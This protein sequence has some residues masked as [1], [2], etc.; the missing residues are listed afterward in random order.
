MFS[1]PKRSALGCIIPQRYC[2]A[3][4][5]FYGL[6]ILM[7]LLFC[8]ALQAQTSL[9]LDHPMYGSTNSPLRTHVIMKS[10][11]VFADSLTRNFNSQR[12]PTLIYLM[13][14][15]DFTTR[16]DSVWRYL[17]V[18]LDV[19]LIDSVTLR[20]D[21][22]SGLYFIPSTY[23]SLYIKNLA[24]ASVTNTIYKDTVLQNIF[25]TTEGLPKPIAYSFFEA[26]KHF[27]YC[28]DTLKI[29]LS[30]T[31]SSLNTTQGNVLQLEE[32]NGW[33]IDTSTQTSSTSYTTV[34]SNRW[35]STDNKTMFI[36]PQSGFV[37]GKTYR[38]HVN[39]GYITGDS[40]DNAFHMIQ[41]NATVPVKIV[42]SGLTPNDVFDSTFAAT[43]KSGYYP[44]SVDSRDT[45][46]A[47]EY[48]MNYRFVGW[49]SQQL[50]KPL[51]SNRTFP[52][53]LSCSLKDTIT[54]EA[55]YTQVA[56]DTFY[57]TGLTNDTI[58]S[59]TLHHQSSFFTVQGYK[60]SLG[61]NVFT[62]YRSPHYSMTVTAKNKAPLTLQQWSYTTGTSTTSQSGGNY[63]NFNMF[64]P[65]KNWSA[66]YPNSHYR[67][68]VNWRSTT[69]P[70]M[71]CSTYTYRATVRVTG[72]EKEKD[73]KG[74][75]MRDLLQSNMSLIESETEN[76]ITFIQPNWPSPTFNLTI[77][78]K[79]PYRECYILVDAPTGTDYEEIMV[80]GGLCA[81]STVIG[82][83]RE[84]K[85]IIVD[86]LLKDKEPMPYATYKQDF[87][88]IV[89]ID[90]DGEMLP[91]Q[92]S[93]KRTDQHRYAAMMPYGVERHVTGSEDWR[94][95]VYNAYTQHHYL[96]RVERRYTYY[97]ND[98]AVFEAE[99]RGENTLAQHFGLLTWVFNPQ[100]PEWQN[101]LYCK[102]MLCP[103][104]SPPQMLPKRRTVDLL[105]KDDIVR[106]RYVFEGKFR[107]YGI[108]FDKGTG[109]GRAMYSKGWKDFYP[110]KNGV[111]DGTNNAITVE[112]DRLF[113]I[114]MN[115]TI[116]GRG[117]LPSLPIWNQPTPPTPQQRREALHRKYAK[118]ELVYSRAVE[119]N[120]AT[121]KALT[122]NTS[123]GSTRL[124]GADRST[125]S[126]NLRADKLPNQS[127]TANTANN[128]TV[129]V[130]NHQDSIIR[131]Y[132]RNNS[133][134]YICHSTDVEVLPRFA[135]EKNTDNVQAP[136]VQG[137]NFNGFTQQPGLWYYF[138][139]IQ[140]N[141]AYDNCM[142]SSRPDIQ[143]FGHTSLFR[144][145]N[146][147]DPTQ[148]KT[149]FR[150]AEP[151][152]WNT[153]EDWCCFP[154]MWGFTAK[155]FQ[156][157][158]H[159]DILL[160]RVTVIDRGNGFPN[161]SSWLTSQVLGTLGLKSIKDELGLVGS[162]A[163]YGAG[164][165][166]NKIIGVVKK[167]LGGASLVLD[168]LNKA[169]C[170]DRTM[171]NFQV[172]GINSV[173][174][175]LMQPYIFSDN[176]EELIRMDSWLYAQP[177]TGNDDN[178]GHLIK[179][180]LSSSRANEAELYIHWILGDVK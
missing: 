142:F 178:A 112:Q 176:N 86:F 95:E 117:N 11:R 24:F 161:I 152:D 73:M 13:T 164:F 42:Y 151:V 43:D 168:F 81:A 64:P 57:L 91:H 162:S 123:T 139:R 149:D 110:E 30:S 141:E 165:S 99:L 68:N 90:N 85:H 23:Y 107:L 84:K 137:V 12:S 34:S 147:S 54:I 87:F 17:T 133:P 125:I 150:T 25:K 106:L 67:V 153:W 175:K 109:Y 160:S 128:N 48:F 172:L 93:E 105:I 4:S 58:P 46:H 18:P 60:D 104:N 2:Y 138:D 32:Q 154:A 130:A 37:A 118:V 98:E 31:I 59:A 70:T 44:Y 19:S 66:N 156:P 22:D 179:V 136:L 119:M 51:S 143:V 77:S 52:F 145:F 76:S 1:L 101:G 75:P 3:R 148:Q 174:N 111:V 78:V 180:P 171:G 134:N 55:V 89:K 39:M 144:Q 50:N 65:W 124:F 140:L 166:S 62:L 6:L 9:V 27:P 167:W 126:G 97:C 169:S 53:Y 10:N 47:D 131:F 177:N 20:I 82:I 45:L 114:A 14:N 155:H 40:K 29:T 116:P 129:I 80:A 146:N 88:N 127:Y 103:Q 94:K 5:K 8:C 56:V 113:P 63:K 69:N 120:T 7:G 170:D 121:N 102:D 132:L 157:T 41:P 21:L 35:L 100:H 135:V 33:N 159:N 163:K 83:Q 16:G 108:S 38:L 96:E 61:T 71:E 26:G 158:R 92:K 74:V 115:E 36:K 122:Q 49:K 28:N 79:E 72:N 15:E 173:E